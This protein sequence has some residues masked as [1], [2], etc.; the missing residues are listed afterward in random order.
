VTERLGLGPDACA[1]INPGLIYARMT[2]W[3]Q[4]GPLPS[5]AGH[6]INYIAVTGL[7]HAIGPPSGPPAVPLNLVG[8]FGGGSLYL[9]VGVLAA[10]NERNRSGRGQVI[11]AGIVDGA[12]HLTTLMQSMIPSGDWQL[13]R[14]ANLLDG[15]ILR[16]LRNR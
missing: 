11:D 12:A 6:D 10:L 7:L 13:D 16:N 2:G 9:V 1:E 3:G 15:V 5:T 14:E 4:T 8:D